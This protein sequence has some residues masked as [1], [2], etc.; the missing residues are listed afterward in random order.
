MTN[1]QD[2]ADVPARLLRL[3]L[4]AHQEWR[5][6]DARGLYRRVLAV[7]PGHV[8]ALYYAGQAALQ[9]NA[10]AEACDLFG[11]LTAAD[12]GFAEGHYYLGVAHLAL[13][14]PEVAMPA[15]DKALSLDPGLA[16]AQLERGNCLRELNRLEDSADAYRRAIAMKPDLVGASSNLGIVLKQ[17][18]RI[19]EA[20]AAYRQ[21]IAAK[22]DFA[23]AHFNLAVLLH[24]MR[25]FAQAETAYLRAIELR[26]ELSVARFNFANLLR[27]QGRTE[28]A[29]AAYR[30]ALGIHPDHAV[31]HVNLGTMLK[32]IGEVDQSIRHFHK[33]IELD[34]ELATAHAGLGA[35]LWTA[36]DAEA[37]LSAFER[38][39]AIRPDHL[40]ALAGLTAVCLDQGDQTRAVAAYGRALLERK[41]ADLHCNL[42]ETHLQFG[43]NTAALASCE[44]VLA[45]NPVHVPTLART[46]VALAKLGEEDE[47]ARLH[48]FETLILQ[49]PCGPPDG[50]ADLSAFNRALTRHVVSHPTLAADPAGHATR[51]GHHTGNL[52]LEPKGPILF[53]EGLVRDAVEAYRGRCDAESDHPVLG[54]APEHW[55]LYMWAIVLEAS[56]HQIP[57]VHPGGWLSGVYYVQTPDIVGASENGNAGWIEFGRPPERYGVDAPVTRS[58][59]P[60]EGHMLLF[61]S[62]MYHRTI[63]FDD[64]RARISIAFDIIPL[65]GSAVPNVAASSS[66]V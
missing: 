23:E 47:L 24:D 17:L 36:G 41:S 2:G 60:Q 51:N 45:L 10:V 31:S 32:Q 63:P 4:A 49:F 21:A 22:P 25:S 58:I 35:A 65:A 40:E 34:P 37:S 12:P 43:N 52:L 38:G 3:A 33:A 62:Y 18:G 29:A 57:H 42:A 11:R 27:D 13:G 8:D 14:E 54:Y 5:L 7:D 26:P 6:D 28:D 59:R 56:G 15:L 1:G 48:D 20:I 61:P 46:T 66:A 16:D 64:T 44:D 53:L 55:S 9:S 39:L 50:F 30:A 19:N